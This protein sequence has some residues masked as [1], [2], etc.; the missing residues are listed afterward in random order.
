VLGENF[1]HTVLSHVIAGP[2][3]ARRLSELVERGWVLPAHPDNP[4]LFRFK[5]TLTR[6]TIYATLLTS[7]LRVLWEN[8]CQ[9]RKGCP[10]SPSPV[11]KMVLLA[12]TRSKHA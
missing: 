9:S 11:G 4:L 8:A 6:E 1:D 3:V 5:H 12:T 10:G 7:K 2:A